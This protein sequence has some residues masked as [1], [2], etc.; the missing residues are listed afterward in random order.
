MERRMNIE[1]YGESKRC[2]IAKELFERTIDKLHLVFLPIPTTKDGKIINGSDTE[3]EKIL[4]GCGEGTLIV[5]YKI[6]LNICDCILNSGARYLDL[7]LDEK[8]V[9]DNAVL[10]AEGALGYIL[11]SFDTSL[12]DMKIG[13]VGYGRIGKALF[14]MI[15]FL[16]GRARVYTTSEKNA[17]ELSE[18]GYDVSLTVG[19]VRDF[20]GLDLLVNTA[21]TNLAPSFKGGKIPDDMRIIELASGDNFKGVEGVE[22]LSSIPE[23]MYPVSGGKIY[24]QAILRF[25]KGV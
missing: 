15:S 22:Y 23:L 14:R 3:I 12:S 24:Y 21:P 4:E 19:G 6:P 20:R 25:L 7:S 16:G 17:M 11:S 13:I 10:S 5:G 8:F 2:R 18:N 9:Y 1:K